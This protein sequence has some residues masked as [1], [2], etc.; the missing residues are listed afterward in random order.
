MFQLD[1]WYLDLVTPEGDVVIGYAARIAWGGLGFNFSSLLENPVD[2]PI[3]DRSIVRG[4]SDPTESPDCVRWTNDALGFAG[5]WTGIAPIEERLVNS[6]AGAINWRCLAPRA[7]VA[8]DVGGRTRTGHGYVERLSL[9]IPPWSLPFD[10]LLWGRFTSDRHSVIWI[11]WTGTTHRR[12]VWMNGTLAPDAIPT[13]HGV[14]GLGHGVTLEWNAGRDLRNR[15][16]LDWL[17]RELPGV[18][19]RMTGRLDRMHEHKVVSPA[20]LS[21]VEPEAEPGWAI[22]EEVR[23]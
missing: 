8:I 11:E 7:N 12:W 13:A 5:T 1:K 10:R 22:H 17:G 4:T 14:D 20:L 21:G 6:P 3:S 16:V 18:A 19:R 23:W 2:G 15:S 9:S